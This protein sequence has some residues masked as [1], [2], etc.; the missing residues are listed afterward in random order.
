MT[1]SPTPIPRMLTLKELGAL[2]QGYRKL[3]LWTEQEL[4]ERANLTLNQIMEVE[5][6][7]SNDPQTLRALALAFS[8]GD[9][10][11]FNKPILIPTSEEFDAQ[12]ESLESVPEGE[13]LEAFVLL[14]GQELGALMVQ[15]SALAVNRSF[16][17]GQQGDMVFEALTDYLREYRQCIDEYSETR[18]ADI[19][20]E[21]QEYLDELKTLGVSIS[22]ASRDIA[23]DS[24]EEKQLDREASRVLYLIAF[25][26]GEEPESFLV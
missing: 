15:S 1:S 14:S 8:F 19:H 2:I 9:A 23:P 10:D 5:S 20:E 24:P 3:R 11:V 18:I 4:A 6:E 26:V 21:F 17:L 25:P 22:Y 7:Q 16:E 13:N 12:S